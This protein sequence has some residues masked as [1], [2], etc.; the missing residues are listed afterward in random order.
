MIQSRRRIQKKKAKQREMNE[1]NRTKGQDS[2]IVGTLLI[3][4]ADVVAA[5]GGGRGHGI[6]HAICKMARFGK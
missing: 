1:E 3:K 2:L 5:M 6:Y 4:Q